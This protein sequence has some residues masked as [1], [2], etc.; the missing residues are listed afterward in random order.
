MLLKFSTWF[1]RKTINHVNPFTK[2]TS[3]TNWHKTF[4]WP[5]YA[6]KTAGFVV[7]QP[8]WLW[9]QLSL[10]PSYSADVLGFAVKPSISLFPSPV[11]SAVIWLG[12]KLFWGSS[13]DP[14]NGLLTMCYSFPICG[15]FSFVF[16]CVV[17]GAVMMSMPIIFRP[18][19][20]VLLFTLECRPNGD[21]KSEAVLWLRATGLCRRSH[22]LRR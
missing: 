5:G 4:T 11:H 12:H 18:S 3:S 22:E 16:P 21:R 7:W 19:S 13:K 10:S 2:S 1:S 17:H 8:L 14:F 20:W 15:E 9:R 6:H